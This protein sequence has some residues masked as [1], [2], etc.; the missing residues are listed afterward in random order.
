VRRCA[1]R[2]DRPASSAPAAPIAAPTSMSARTV[3]VTCLPCLLWTMGNH[4]KLHLPIG[5]AGR[6]MR[7]SG[8]VPRCCG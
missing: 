7:S 1:A 5:G 2:P 3:G 6:V 8:W 4:G